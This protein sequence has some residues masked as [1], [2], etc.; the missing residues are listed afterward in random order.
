MIIVKIHDGGKVLAICDKSLIG[1]KFEEKGLCLDVNENFYGGEAMDEKR[2]LNF[3]D[4][5]K[6]INIV[7]KESI[8]F[9]LNKKIISKG[10]IIEINKVPHA[11][12]F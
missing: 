2:I 11:Q 5:A 12:V 10:H 8:K 3:V 1:K 9:A 4:S 6:T 7:G